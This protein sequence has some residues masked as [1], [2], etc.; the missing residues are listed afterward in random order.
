MSKVH[1]VID[2]LREFHAALVRF[3]YG[4]QGAVDR[5][6]DRIETARA[7]LAEK[8]ERWRAELDRSRAEDEDCRQRAADSTG[9]DAGTDDN[10]VD[11]SRLAQAVAD[12]EEHIE[13][14]RRWQ[15]RIDEEAS[16]FHDVRGRFRDRLDY[17]LPRAEAHLTALISRLEAAR[18]AGEA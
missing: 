4:Q 8:A 1:A 9:S 11:C 3:R 15:L 7:E 14:I 5:D 6:G 17:D 12:A 18:A 2:A 10:L 16:I 13:R